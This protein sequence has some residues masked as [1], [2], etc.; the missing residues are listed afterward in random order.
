M[1]GR[2]LTRGG[3]GPGPPA[4]TYPAGLTSAG[5][6]Y[7]LRELSRYLVD[8]QVSTTPEGMRVAGALDVVGLMTEESPAYMFLTGMTPRG[9]PGEVD[10]STASGRASILLEPDTWR[11]RG[12]V[13]TLSYHATPSAPD[14]PADLVAGLSPIE[15]TYLCLLTVSNIDNPEIEITV[16]E[17]G[18]A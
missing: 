6:A 1:E 9:F 12:L 17:I 11:F 15:F 7:A 3:Q 16:P 2:L 18:E 14:L 8:P 5:L 4:G 10:F 13:A